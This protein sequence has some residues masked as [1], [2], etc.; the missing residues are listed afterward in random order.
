MDVF[1]R[2]M[3]A[4]QLILDETGKL[5]GGNRSIGYNDDHGV[6]FTE[7]IK[8]LA[9][10]LEGF[11]DGDGCRA[12][13]RRKRRTGVPCCSARGARRPSTVRGIVKR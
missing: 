12:A 10:Q 5:E 9:K 6:E 13:G 7:E 4:Q 2:T 11:L 1:T 3:M 8:A